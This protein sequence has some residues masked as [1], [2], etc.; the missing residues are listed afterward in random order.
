M[1][2]FRSEED[3]D[4]WCATWRLTRGAV[5]PIDLGWRLAKAWYGEDRREPSWHRRNTEQAQSV[6][7]SLGL[8][9]DFWKLT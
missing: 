2:Y 1:L 9:S 6:F 5:I 8:T 7:T 3:V 4:R